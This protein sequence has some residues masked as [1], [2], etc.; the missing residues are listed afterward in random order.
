[1]A[2]ALTTTTMLPHIN[3]TPPT[4]ASHMQT[5]TSELDE[6]TRHA[7]ILKLA[8][9]VIIFLISSIGNSMVCVIILRRKTMKTV[10]NYFIL[11]LAIADLAL[12]CIC[13]PFDIPV[14]EM[15]YVWPYGGFMCKILYPLQTL[16]LFASIYTLTAVSLTRYW[17]IVHPLKKQLTVVKAKFVI[18]GIWVFSLI[19]V[20][21][22]II[23][24]KYDSGKKSCDESWDSHNTRKVYTAFLFTSQYVLPLIVIATAYISI[25]L[26]LH[27]REFVTE[28][29]RRQQLEETRKIV[30]MLIVV[31][32]LFAACMLP[33]NIMWMWLD[34]GQADKHFNYFWEVIA[35]SNILTFAN[36]AANPLCYTILNENYR[37]EFKSALQFC[38]QRT[39]ERVGNQMRKGSSLS[40]FELLK[41]P[42][43]KSTTTTV[44]TL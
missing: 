39:E 9:Y 16:A 14:Q 26:E 15:N 17:A 19:P 22:Y 28:C 31:T 11:N 1:M 27:K 42:R 44:S 35:F 29:L 30:R 36:S 18:F 3:I 10:T 33:N 5:S 4:N 21:P 12:T 25:A 34:F 43:S 38:W 37:K 8:L 24:L 6:Y 23:I 40:G 32:V 2:K 41:I 13:I 7:R 20:C